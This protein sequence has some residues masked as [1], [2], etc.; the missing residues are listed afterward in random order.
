MHTEVLTTGRYAAQ[1]ARLLPTDRKLRRIFYDALDT[2]NAVIERIC[3]GVPDPEPASDL[4]A[5]ID[6]QLRWEYP[7]DDEVFELV[8]NALL[9]HV[10]YTCAA[11]GALD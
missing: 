7:V 5:E 11:A 2:A 10:Y 3:A 4:L 9:D 1:L 8:W 6:H